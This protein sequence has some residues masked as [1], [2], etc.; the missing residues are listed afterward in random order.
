MIPKM[1]WPKLSLCF[2]TV[3]ALQPSLYRLC[4]SVICASYIPH[5]TLCVYEWVGHVTIQGETQRR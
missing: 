5:S 3:G 1:E 2:W 4:T